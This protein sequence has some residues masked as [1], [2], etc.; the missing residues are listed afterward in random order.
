[1]RPSSRSGQRAQ[2]DRN[3]REELGGVDVALPAQI[4]QQLVLRAAEVVLEQKAVQQREQP[5]AV[6]F[7]QKAPD[8]LFR[9]AYVGIAALD[10]VK[11]V[12]NPNAAA[13]GHGGHRLDTR[14]GFFQLGKKTHVD[15]P[16]LTTDSCTSYLA[17]RKGKICIRAP[18]LPPCVFLHRNA[19]VPRAAPPQSRAPKR[20]TTALG[21]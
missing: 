7:L 21:T 19:A 12:I 1:M 16:V 3:E 4:G 6:L 8:R 17:R 5:V 14:I 10:E 2:Q 15:I 13:L 18:I 9:R 11:V 20:R